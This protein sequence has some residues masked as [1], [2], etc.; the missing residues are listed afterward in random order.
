[1]TFTYTDLDQEK[2][3]GFFSKDES[4]GLYF[5][6]TWGGGRWIGSLH[7]SDYEQFS[8]VNSK[9]SKK[10]Q[11]FIDG[12]VIDFDNF[13]PKSNLSYSVFS[14]SEDGIEEHPFEP[15]Y[16]YKT[17]KKYALDLAKKGMI[18][19]LTEAHLK[20]KTIVPRKDPIQPFSKRKVNENLFFFHTRTGI[21]SNLIS[22]E[23]NSEIDLNR[24][25]SWMRSGYSNMVLAKRL[26]YFFDGEI[27]LFEKADPDKKFAVFSREKHIQSFKNYQEAVEYCRTKDKRGKYPCEFLICEELNYM[28]WH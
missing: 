17:I 13:I 18:V 4:L 10:V 5:G 28:S 9:S 8:G 7:V 14:K 24:L 25:D 1:M 3:D 26:A 21:F 11:L 23:E 2:I 19:L 27:T 22:A 15:N 16:S 20:V 12:E 6:E